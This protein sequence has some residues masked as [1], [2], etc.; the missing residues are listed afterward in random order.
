[1]IS[2][3]SFYKHLDTNV[4]TLL[5]IN[6]KKEQ[7]YLTLLALTKRCD[8]QYYCSHSFTNMKPK[9][10]Y[11]SIHSTIV[12]MSCRLWMLSCCVMCQDYISNGWIIVSDGWIISET[13]PLFNCIKF[14]IV[15]CCLTSMIQLLQTKWSYDQKVNLEFNHFCFLL[16]FCFHPVQSWCFFYFSIGILLETYVWFSLISLTCW[17]FF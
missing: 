5:L 11:W 3:K 12:L 4:Q 9:S 15:H 6:T 10:I 17:Y 8:L 13:F 16:L 14:H 7:D 2:K 1:M